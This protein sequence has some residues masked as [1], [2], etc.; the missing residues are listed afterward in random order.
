VRHPDINNPFWQNIP[1]E[2][3]CRGHKKTGERCQRPA[4][5]GGTVC[6]HHGG[7]AAHVKKA[8]Q[9]RMDNFADRAA[10]ILI[11]I[12]EAPDT[13]HP[14]KLAAVKDL[15]DRCGLSARTAVDVNL[16]LPRYA[17]LFDK[18]ARDTSLGLDGAPAVVDGEVV[19]DWGDF[20]DGREA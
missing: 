9:A 14:V 1:E 8:A 20:G 6:R 10:R 5:L 3:R 19:A 16:E 11:G 12:A 13:P 17:R 7:A 4:I 15:L 18:I 2:R